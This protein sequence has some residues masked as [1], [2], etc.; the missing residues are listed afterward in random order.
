MLNLGMGEVV[1][2]LLVAFLIV[3]P[4]D[5]PKVARWLARQVNKAR[6]FIREIKK[7][8]GWDELTREFRDTADDLKAAAKD[9]DVS[10]D[11][12]DAFSEAKKG[13]NDAAKSV[14]S[15]EKDLKDSIHDSQ[16]K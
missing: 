8:T 16:T 11:L 10:A 7:E 14:Q 1:L 4:K 15:V 12:K 2:V 3:G 5:L 9:V 13:I 6:Q